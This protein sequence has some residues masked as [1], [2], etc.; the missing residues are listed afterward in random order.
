VPAHERVRKP[1]HKARALKCGSLL[2]PS[3]CGYLKGASKLAHSK[4]PFGRTIEPKVCGVSRDGGAPREPYAVVCVLSRARHR[5]SFNTTCVTGRSLQP[6]SWGL[7][8]TTRS[9]GGVFISGIWRWRVNWCPGLK[10]Y[11]R[12]LIAGEKEKISKQYIL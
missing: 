4:A 11:F 3:G 8:D 9:A 5:C 12:S 2:P 7:P 10:F 1:Q 6:P